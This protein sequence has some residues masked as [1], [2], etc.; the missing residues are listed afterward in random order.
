MAT[1]TTRTIVRAVVGLAV[2][3]AGFAVFNGLKQMRKAP[4]QQPRVDR[5]VLVE[6]AAATITREPVH[7]S[8]SGT[9][10]PARSVALSAEVGGRVVW[11][12]KELVPGGRIAAGK[13]LFRIDARDYRL[14]VEQQFAAVDRAR[15]ELELERG[16]KKIAQR[17]W[18]LLGAS[19]GVPGTPADEPAATGGNLALREPQMRSAEVA[20]KAAES[21][22]QRAR[23][24]VGKTGV[25]VPWN[26][27]VQQRSVDIGQLVTP[28]QPLATLV[29]TDEFWVQALI[30]VDRL[31]WIQVPGLRGATAGSVVKIRQ[32]TMGAPIE[33]TGQVV[34]LMGDLD[35]AGRMARVLISVDDPLGLGLTTA[36]ATDAQAD[37]L[38]L[39]VGAYVE[40]EIEGGELTDVIAVPRAALHGGDTVYVDA[41]GH[42][43]MKQLD[44]LWRRADSV[45]VGAGLAPGDHVVL[46]PVPGAV[47]GMKLRRQGA[48]DPADAR[49]A[50]A[51]PAGAHP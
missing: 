49:P 19:G 37:R 41:D 34:R 17:E 1:T 11:M 46:S 31:R 29:G 13:P 28:G 15:T 51:A 22:L 44:I 39:L 24:A 40:V 20:V 25:S 36:A 4:P 2:L 23:L 18:E 14:A 21:G 47:A 9:V 30:P 5:G 43:E 45:L 7:I 42:L 27:L 32:R 26:A 16:R 35:P 6:T 33:R 38:P 10:V 48:P 50:D 3:L 12:A 8:A